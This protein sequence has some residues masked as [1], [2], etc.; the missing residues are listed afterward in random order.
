MSDI[1]EVNRIG[2]IIK[3]YKKKASQLRSFF[4]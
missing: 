4:F 3:I 2:E 1:E